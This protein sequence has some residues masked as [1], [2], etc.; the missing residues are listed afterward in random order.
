MARGEPRLRVALLVD[1]LDDAD[2]LALVVAHGHGQD[3]LR[4]VAGALVERAAVAVGRARRQRVG[5][6]QVDHVAGQGGV[7][8]DRRLGERHRELLERHLH[9]VVLGPL[10]AQQVVAGALVVLAAL[11]LVEA[12]RVRR[13]QLAR[14]RQDQLE[15]LADVALGGERDADLVELVQVAALARQRLLQAAHRRPLLGGAS[16]PRAQARRAD[17]LRQDAVQEGELL[18][19]HLRRARGRRGQHLGARRCRPR[20]ARRPRPRGRVRSGRDRRG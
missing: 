18:G 3:R 14:A 5:V 13:G 1:E 15:Q 17:R 20:R 12:A 19:E 9:R 16:Q 2:H 4:A 10:E 11:D 8:G 7:P 6:R